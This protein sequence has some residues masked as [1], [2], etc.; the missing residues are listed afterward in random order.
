[1]MRPQPA[2][3]FVAVCARDDA[4]VLLEAL[5]ASAHAQIE[6]HAGGSA[7]RAAATGRSFKEYADLA[8]RYRAYWP[9]ARLRPAAER[10]EPVAAFDSALARL[11]SWAADCD[12]IIATLQ[13]HEGELG[14]LAALR[15]VLDEMQASPVDLAQLGS[16]RASVRSRI[17]V[18]PAGSD[19]AIPDAVLVHR[20]STGAD[21]YAVVLGAAPAVEQLERE[22]VALR[23]HAV[24]FPAW[25]ERDAGVSRARADARIA[26][27]RHESAA[28]RE[29]LDACAARQEVALALGDVE[30]AAW[31]FEN[32][33]A[34]EGEGS[35]ARISGWTD[36]GERLAAAVESSGA[37]ALVSFPPAPP[38]SQPPL[39][40]RNPWWARP[41]ELF[42]RIFGMPG[43]E[44]ADPS[45]LLAVATPFIFGYMFG[46][47]GQGLV[48]VAVG[49]A[50]RRR[51]PAL[52]LLV[53]GGIAAAAFGLAFGSVFGRE[54]LVEALWVAPLREPLRVLVVPIFAGALLLVAGL[55][56]HALEAWWRRAMREW[57]ACD[58]G[59]VAVYLGAL[60]VA[61]HAA[62]GFALAACG[63]VAF[64]AGRALRAGTWRAVPGAAGALLE[65]TL[66]IL[67]NTLS[68]ARVGAF[69]LAHAGLSAALVA[70]AEAADSRIGGLAALV[71]GNV[72][73]IVLEG[74]IVAIQTTRL[75]LFEFFVR[76]F[77]SRGREFRPLL[78][79]APLEEHP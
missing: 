15:R 10:K 73:V 36:D 59:F 40:L 50:L 47:L 33:G 8:R 60:L 30:R 67:V 32:V 43:R 2:R 62:A 69:A 26:S 20:F 52:R 6:W 44:G 37:R 28:A 51:Y 35:L 1:M 21:L 27:L 56:L 53:P 58:S 63:A 79:P 57:L 55:A 76:F 64:V 29:T 11:R 16:A 75:V 48:L 25:L 49:L 19:P 65:R 70:L 66:Q 7:P 42:S 18:Y 31:C 34:I 4:F 46:D 12:P 14:E 3:W 41:F 17:L 72:V 78:P 22:A 74:L 77:E 61:F 39:L 13:R 71:V 9:R 5:A 23:G 24:G 38:G 54:D 68:F 45:V